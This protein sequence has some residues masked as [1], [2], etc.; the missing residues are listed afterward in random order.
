MYSGGDVVTICGE[1][2]G[3]DYRVQGE[4]VV[5][6]DWHRNTDMCYRNISVVGFIFQSG[7]VDKIH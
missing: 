4:A 5:G 6:G 1:W 7:E 2:K 3:G